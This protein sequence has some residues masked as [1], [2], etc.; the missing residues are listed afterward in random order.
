MSAGE[1]VEEGAPTEF[2]QNPRDARTQ[3]FLGKILVH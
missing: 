1:I 3:S 2:F